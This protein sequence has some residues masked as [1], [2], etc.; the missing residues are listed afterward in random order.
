MPNSFTHPSPDRSVWILT[1]SFANKELQIKNTAHEG[2]GHGYV[3]EL[4]RNPQSA[5]H[6]YKNVSK[7]DPNDMNTWYFIKVPT[8]HRLEQQID[9]VVIEAI[10]NFKSR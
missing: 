10:N 1:S 5:S 6:Q 9:R 8:N 3:Y 7:G 4:T 2:F